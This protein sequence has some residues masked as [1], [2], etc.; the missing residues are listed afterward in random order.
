M[1]GTV[2]NDA[3]NNGIQDTGELGLV[4]RIVEMQPGNRYGTTDSTGFYQIRGNSLGT[5]NVGLVP[6]QYWFQTA[7]TNPN[8][9]SVTFTAPLQVESNKDFGVRA[10][11]PITDDAISMACG[12]VR[13]GRTASVVL[14]LNNLGTV[15]SSGTITMQYDPLLTFSSSIPAQTS[16]NSTTRTLTW[17]YSNLQ[18]GAFDNYQVFFT[19]PT[20]AT[21]GA[22]VTNTVS[23]L[24]T[25]ALDEDTTS[26]YDTCGTV[27][28]GSYD[29]NDKRVIPAGTGPEN[30]VD[31][32]TPLRYTIRFQNTGTDTAF[33]VRV[34]DQLDPDLDPTTFR[35]LGASHPFSYNI[36]GAGLVELDLRSH[37]FTG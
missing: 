21:L 19:V 33:Y 13:P 18:P 4:N 11:A 17:N 6:Q 26:N 30:R 34:E 36:Q 27:V 15:A 31:P 16:H 14:M 7:P 10:P 37:Y 20:N 9:H 1:E 12:P 23:L 32:D 8:T 28:T 24:T 29:P 35:M 22:S 25:S 5:F 3:N 2:Y